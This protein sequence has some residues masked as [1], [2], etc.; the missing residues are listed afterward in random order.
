MKLILNNYN[1]FSLFRKNVLPSLN[2]LKIY[3]VS[4]SDHCII[5][6]NIFFNKFVLYS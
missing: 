4:T 3:Y 6:I 1:I 5:L 2:K